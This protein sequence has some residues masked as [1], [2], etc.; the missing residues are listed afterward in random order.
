VSIETELFFYDDFPNEEIQAIDLFYK[1]RFFCFKQSVANFR[2]PQHDQ[3]NHP[4]GDQGLGL[5][6]L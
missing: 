3:D 4:K 6:I 5:E 1:Y 2:F